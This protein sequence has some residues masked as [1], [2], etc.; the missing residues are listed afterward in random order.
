MSARPEGD[1]SW[2][3]EALRYHEL[4]DEHRR[5]MSGLLLSL[6]D[7]MDSF[8]RVLAHADSGDAQDGTSA[9]RLIARQL[10]SVLQRMKVRPLQCLG[11][12]VDVETQEVVSVRNTAPEQADVVVEVVRRGYE[13]DGRLLRTA[14][15]IVGRSSEENMT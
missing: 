12:V 11:Q 14:Q 4:Q 9:C 6:L 8:D 1:G 7:V 15:V 10:D 13:W 3:L 5:E 2:L